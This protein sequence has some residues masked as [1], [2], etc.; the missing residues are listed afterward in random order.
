MKKFDRNYQLD[1]LQFYNRSRYRKWKIN[2][3]ITKSII[4]VIRG[5]DLKGIKL[6]KEAIKSPVINEVHAS[7]LKVIVRLNAV[8]ESKCKMLGIEVEPVDETH[9][10]LMITYTPVEG[11]DTNRQLE[12]AL[13]VLSRDMKVVKEI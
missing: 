13:Q 6:H 11:L 10:K 7:T 9:K 2:L 5:H 8:S 12:H 1:K 3:I 4:Y